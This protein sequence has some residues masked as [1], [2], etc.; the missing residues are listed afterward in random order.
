MTPARTLFPLANVPIRERTYFAM[1]G[2][3]MVLGG[4][5]VGTLGAWHRS[6]IAFAA[7]ELMVVSGAIAVFMPLWVGRT[8]DRVA[9]LLIG[10]ALTWGLV[11]LRPAYA[12]LAMLLILFLIVFRNNAKHA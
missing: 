9:V 6:S 3:A 5:L 12:P 8:R 2:A 7:S 10:V 11:A 1:G 4:I